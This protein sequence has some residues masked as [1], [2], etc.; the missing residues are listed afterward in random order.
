MHKITSIEHFVKLSKLFYCRCDKIFSKPCT[1]YNH[2]CQKPQKTAY[3]YFCVELDSQQSQQ[4]DMPVIA[5]SASVSPAM[6]TSGSATVVNAGLPVPSGMLTIQPNDLVIVQ[7]NP[8]QVVAPTIIQPI[9]NNP[10][11]PPNQTVSWS[12][13]N[14]QQVWSLN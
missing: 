5:S 12:T 2:D 14:S 7:P 8:Q 13:Q 1:F 3:C 4:K 9:E 6:A 10:I 11:N